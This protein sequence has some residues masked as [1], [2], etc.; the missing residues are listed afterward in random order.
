MYRQRQFGRCESDITHVV[1][2][3]NPDS[4][5]AASYEFDRH[6]AILNLLLHRFSQVKM[7]ALAA[8]RNRIMFF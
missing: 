1:N 7:L 2:E 8:E 3:S 4:L 5:I 6:P